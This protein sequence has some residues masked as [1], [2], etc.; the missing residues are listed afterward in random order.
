MRTGKGV[1][2]Y[3]RWFIPILF[4]L[5]F[6]LFLFA[7]LQI[8][9]A[10]VTVKNGLKV[11]E[12]KQPV[13]EFPIM[14]VTDQDT[15]IMDDKSEA[16]TGL[17]LHRPSIGEVFGKV[18]IPKLKKELPLIEGT[19][20]K[21]LAVGVG[22]YEYSVLPGEHDNTV[23]AGHRDT[24]FRGLGEVSEGDQVIVETAAGS[25]IYQVFNQRIVDKDDRTVIVPTADPILTLVTCYPFD[26]IGA[27]PQ[28]FILSAK[29]I[30]NQKQEE[31]LP[32]DPS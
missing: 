15:K 28:R 12:E 31:E 9:K 18:T 8:V 16:Q 26:Y 32:R 24:V 3:C 11:W 7:L 13:V 22:H 25:F 20:E 17:Y 14:P 10:E 27:A 2:T 23:L 30:T 21:E 5:S 4:F 1:Q 29:L 19:D 6:F